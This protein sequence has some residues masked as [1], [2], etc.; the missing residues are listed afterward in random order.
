MKSRVSHQSAVRTRLSCE[1]T[2]GYNVKNGMYCYDWC[3]FCGHRTDGDDHD[4]L[5]I[6]PE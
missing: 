2:G 4:T 5:V 3:P 1:R 6:A